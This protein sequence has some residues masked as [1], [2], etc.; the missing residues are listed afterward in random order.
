M[1]DP[2]FADL[3]G[4]TLRACTGKVGDDEIIFTVNKSSQYKLYHE[5]DCCENVTIADI[6]GDLADL[7]GTPI[8]QA[9]ESSKSGSDGEYGESYTWTFYRIA[10]MK[11]SVVIRWLGCSNGYYSES[12]SFVKL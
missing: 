2:V 1:S 8:L 10:T 6:C 7:V 5:Q 12:V 11:G 4:K 9:E 3:A